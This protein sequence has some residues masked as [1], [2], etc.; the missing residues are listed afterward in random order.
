MVAGLKSLSIFHQ[1][2]F[3]DKIRGI[4]DRNHLIALFAAIFSLSSRLAT[5]DK[6]P[7]GEDSRNISH[8]ELHALSLQYI[9]SSLEACSS[10]APPLC[11]LQAITLAGY[12]KLVNGVYGPA[13]RLVGTGVRIAYELRLHLVDCKACEKVPTRDS[14]LMMWSSNEERRRCWWA[15]WEMDIFASTIQR[16]PTAIDWSA[17]DTFLPVSDE[18]WFTNTYQASCLLHGSPEERWKRLK[19]SGNENSTAW[20]YLLAS[21]MHDGRLLSQESIKGIISNSDLPND[22]PKLAQYYSQDYRRKAQGFS[23]RLS[24]LVK[25]YQ[26]V[27]ENLP[28]TLAYRGE[29]LSF[30]LAEGEDPFSTRRTSA[31]KYI[32][33]M[34]SASACFMIYQNYVFADIIEG[35]IPLS[36]SQSDE[37]YF[38]RDTASN[39]R[40]LVGK[41]LRN[42]LEASDMVLRLLANCP[43]DHVRYVNPYYASTTWIAAALQVFKRFALRD[44]GST[45]TQR[46]YDLLRRS[47]LQFNQFWETP[48]ALLQNLDSLE[49]RLECR[50]RELELSESRARNTQIN[51][52]QCH[53]DTQSSASTETIIASACE[54]QLLPDWPGLKVS[55][56]NTY[57]PLVS[58]P[59]ANYPALLPEDVE[60]LSAMAPKFDPSMSQATFSE[61]CTETWPNELYLDNL[62]WYS[63]D[64]MAGLS[65]GYTA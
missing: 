27:R 13:W 52:Q 5:E 49:A 59:N 30:A 9:H 50:H 21:L 35:L 40:S 38:G 39:E 43:E 29:Y 64:V 4:Q 42:Y 61:S 36:S 2:S 20:A 46:Q 7:Q 41:G 55:L 26:D 47:Y 28:T 58:D 14:E 62:V 18:C 48:R 53:G 1:P 54:E 25:A 63:S 24:S 8:Q 23:D 57:Q 17:N 11:L 56:C 31:G 16:A 44:H 37:D 10:N 22:V 51:N 33:H 15:L 12:Y 3:P 60:L 34:M 65:H 32:I 6:I 45:L 19:R